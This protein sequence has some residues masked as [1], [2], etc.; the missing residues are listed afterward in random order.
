[1]GSKVFVVGERYR[2]MGPSK[3][4]VFRGDVVEVHVVSKGTVGIRVAASM[5]APIVCM[6]QA[7]A[8]KSLSRISWPR[9]GK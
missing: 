3:P 9:R 2:Y 4:H 1:M 6:S 5:G 7:V 8:E